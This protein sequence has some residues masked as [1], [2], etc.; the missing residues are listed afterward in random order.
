MSN[1]RG[2]QRECQRGHPQS[3][4]ATLLSSEPVDPATFAP[5]HA[6]ST[7]FRIPCRIDG[8]TFS[9]NGRS[10]LLA[11]A[12]LAQHYATTAGH[13]TTCVRCDHVHETPKARKK[14]TCNHAPPPAAAAA[15]APAAAPPAGD[16]AYAHTLASAGSMAK[17]T[18]DPGAPVTMSGLAIAGT[19]IGA[20][21]LTNAER[22]AA[23]AALPKMVSAE[24]GAM[25]CTWA[26]C[27]TPGNFRELFD[28]L[29]AAVTSGPQALS[30]A[31]RRIADDYSGS[32]G[33][34]LTVLKG[35][36]FKT[37]TMGDIDAIQRHHNVPVMFLSRGHCS[38]G[39][40]GAALSVF[41]G[42]IGSRAAVI[43][44]GRHVPAASNTHTFALKYTA[45][46]EATRFAQPLTVSCKKQRR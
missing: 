12:A 35:T 17:T 31:C 33:V 7:T 20:G 16:D 37:T 26:D 21:G 46:Y 13:K 27:L 3:A 4:G 41:W 30:T 43:A 10:Q 2:C 5:H 38:R 1:R 24:L 42:I 34:G 19:V 6:M 8:C 29:L 15:A 36:K 11:S 39:P 14:C 45:I 23:L 28:T 25:N 18:M 22:N 40:Q 44:Y 9:A 32:A